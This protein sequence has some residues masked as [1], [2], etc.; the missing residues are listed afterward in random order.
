MLNVHRISL[1]KTEHFSKRFLDY[2]NQNEK[3]RSLYR[4]AP[5][6][7]SFEKAIKNISSQKFNRTLLV[8][9]ITE[10]YSKANC[11]L[12]T[13]NCQLLLQEDTFTVCTGHQLCLFTGP[14]YFI[15]KI[16]S[17]ITLAE[18]L[19]KKYPESDFVPV[20]WMASEDH[21]FE[22]VN[23]IHL[24]GKKLEWKNKQGGAL[25][26]YSTDGIGELI[27]ELEAILGD[28]KQAR[29]LIELFQNAYT[30]HSDF[31]S[32]TRFLVNELF[33]EYGLVI[34]EPNDTKLKQEFVSVIEEDV[35]SNSSFHLVEKS[36]NQLEKN[37]YKL[38]VNPREIN[39]FYLSDNQRN[40]IVKE[41]D[42][43]NVVETRK[44]FSENE[45]KEEIK[46]HPERFSPNVVT[47]PLY[48]Q[49]ILPNLA[50]VGGAAEISYWLQYKEM[51]DHYKIFF[52]VL[53][54]RNF[55]MIMDET[56]S[57]K[58]MKIG[59][60]SEDV[61]L[62]INEMTEKY[63]TSVSGEKISFNAEKE[64]LKK[65]HKKISE[66]VSLIDASLVSSAEAELQKHLNALDALEK[67]MLR[68]FKQK[69]ETAVSQIEKI[70]QKLFPNG[71]LQERH[72]TFI[73]FYLKHGKNF[74]EDLKRDIDPFDFRFIILS[75]K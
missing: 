11:Q 68:A 66:K 49:K 9:V 26:N 56:V 29:E 23:H 33:G 46:S 65:L 54:P 48:Q 45:L 55:R 72:D 73:P 10:Q 75:E 20:Y 15:Y 27:D 71:E 35:F 2:V 21:D 7:D 36:N 1:E 6:I 38:Q 42:K 47:R 70:K 32:A 61:F 57:E 59:L 39:I 58:L 16:I 12:P 64:Q 4:Y 13:A 34:I 41:N 40:R 67:K 63:S 14:L 60:A 62:S 51:F 53:V 37:G 50:Y 18:Q 28:S 44:S 5:S 19:K 25:G 17:T 74:I 31:S 8:D 3:L 43:F 52:P 24:F 30:K 22:E 69:N